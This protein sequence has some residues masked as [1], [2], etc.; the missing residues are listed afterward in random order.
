MSISPN[1]P[2]ERLANWAT[3]LAHIEQSLVEAIAAVPD[4]PPLEH[5]ASPSEQPAEAALQQLR[6]RLA[7]LEKCAAVALE[8]ASAID[9]G[10]ASEAAALEAWLQGVEETRRKLAKAPA[11]TV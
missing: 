1:P 7:N 10:L 4:P 11:G 9:A 8:Q 2:G 5:L 3:V 6:T